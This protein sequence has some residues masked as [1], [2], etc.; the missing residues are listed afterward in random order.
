MAT[1]KFGVWIA[2]FDG[3]RISGNEAVYQIM[4]IG[5]SVPGMENNKQRMKK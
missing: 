5:E 4:L 2:C 1:D 3:V